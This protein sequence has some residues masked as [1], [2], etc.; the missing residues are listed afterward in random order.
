[1]S[2]IEKLIKESLSEDILIPLKYDKMIYNTLDNINHYKTSLKDKIFK[3]IIGILT[4][5]LSMTGICFAVFETYNYILE[6]QQGK[7]VSN[8]L[9]DI[10]EVT[11]ESLLNNDMKWDKE[12][13]FYYKIIKN[14]EDYTKYKNK[15]E[16]LPHM[17]NEDFESESLL[18]MTSIFPRNPDENNLEIINITDNEDTTFI[19]LDQSENIKKEDFNNVIY[20]I[21]PNKQLK[22]NI[23]IE[24]EH[25]NIHLPGY[26][27]IQKIPTE[28][29]IESAIKDGCLV[30]EK[31]KIKSNNIYSLD[32]LMNKPNDN[33]CIRIYDKVSDDVISI[34]DIIYK[35]GLY[36]M[37]TCNI[38]NPKREI[39]YN[40]FETIQRGELQENGSKMTI[41]SG[42]TQIY[43]SRFSQGIPIIIFSEN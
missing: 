10:D 1:M 35:D 8:G 2:K 41:Y 36:Y 22:E 16:Y 4:T 37:N 14:I 26:E 21:I 13:A 40:S 34:I 7:T 42:M 11:R 12:N 30:L 19:K 15:I 17:Q 28:Y 9:G 5:I 3:I 23:E 29:N 38:S 18:I 32:K 31:S 27:N 20:A 24:I 33:D 6:I 39:E 43:N 25:F